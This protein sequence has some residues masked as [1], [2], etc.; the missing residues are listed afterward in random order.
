MADPYGGDVEGRAG[1]A[2]YSL[3]LSPN[4]PMVVRDRDRGVLRSGLRSGNL[5]CEGRSEIGRRPI[6]DSEWDHHGRIDRPLHSHL[7]GQ[8]DLNQTMQPRKLSRV[9]RLDRVSPYRSKK[10]RAH[11]FEL[12][13]GRWT[14]RLYPRPVFAACELRPAFPYA[15]Y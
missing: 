12:L 8:R 2:A 10:A 7:G 13:R 11:V 15:C 6:R 3:F 14:C 1:W 4:Q 5:S 9:R